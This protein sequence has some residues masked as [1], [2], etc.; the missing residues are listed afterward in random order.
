[1]AQLVHDFETGS[2]DQKDL[3]GGKG[4]NLAVLAPSLALKV[5]SYVN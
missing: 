5:A 3:L 4:A 2:M 1:M